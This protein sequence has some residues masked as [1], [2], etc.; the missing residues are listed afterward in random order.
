[1]YIY[2]LHI[3]L[4]VCVSVCVFYFTLCLITGHLI[5]FPVL[6]IGSCCLSVLHI[7]VCFCV[8]S[9]FF[10]VQQEPSGNLTKEQQMALHWIACFQLS[11]TVRNSLQMEY[12]WEIL[13]S[14][15]S[16]C[17]WNYSHAER[18][19]HCYKNALEI[20]AWFGI[21]I[22]VLSLKH[23]LLS[24]LVIMASLHQRKRSRRIM[25]RF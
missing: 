20:N 25:V 3:L 22:P 1:M 13:T 6:Y 18:W 10:V 24:C 16:F 7:M 23:A 17:K 12:F 11:V 15:L 9:D 5:E 21:Q 8:S 14:S 19:Y 4:W 2:Y